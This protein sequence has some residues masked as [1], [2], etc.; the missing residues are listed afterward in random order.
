M[1]LLG[2]LADL[3]ADIHDKTPPAYV[4]VN[5]RTKKKKRVMR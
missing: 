1:A 3:P 4:L 2:R 5:A